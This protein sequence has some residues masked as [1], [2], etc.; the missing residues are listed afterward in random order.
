MCDADGNGNVALASEA[1]VQAGGN[2][3]PDF[4]LS[5][6][7][8]VSRFPCDRSRS[9]QPQP[10]TSTTFHKQIVNATCARA[11]PCE[12]SKR[13]LSSFFQQVLS[14]FHAQHCIIGRWLL[15]SF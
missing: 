3:N 8:A 14:V 10:L 6:L 5:E 7:F 2:D 4:S 1:P 9:R 11:V 15:A 13:L 12:R